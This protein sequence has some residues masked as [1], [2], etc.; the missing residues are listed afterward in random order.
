MEVTE[1]GFGSDDAGRRLYSIAACSEGVQTS[2]SSLGSRETSGEERDLA[3]LRAVRD[4]F[5]VTFLGL[6]LSTVGVV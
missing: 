5:A 6:A 4:F 1:T 3:F 2:T